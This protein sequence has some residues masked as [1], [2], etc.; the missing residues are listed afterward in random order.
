VT[1]DL[2][3][4]PP[5]SA[6]RLAIGLVVRAFQTGHRVLFVTAAQWATASPGPTTS[7]PFTPK[8]SSL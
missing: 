3:P 5:S 1:L 7:E 4:G 2:S 8:R 6:D